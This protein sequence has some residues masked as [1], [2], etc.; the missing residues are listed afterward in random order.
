MIILLD[1][2]VSWFCRQRNIQKRSPAFNW[3]SFRPEGQCYSQT[4][5]LLSW[6]S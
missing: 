4:Q 3:M 1:C 2:F 6:D 5:T